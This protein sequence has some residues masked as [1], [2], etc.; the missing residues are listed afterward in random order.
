MSG[1]PA[2]NLHIEAQPGGTV[3]ESVALEKAQ[4]VFYHGWVH[5]EEY[6]GCAKLYVLAQFISLLL[7]VPIV[8]CPEGDERHDANQGGEEEHQGFEEPDRGE[9]GAVREQALDRQ[10]QLL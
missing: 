10:H 3:D 5:Q 6:N 1:A 7:L 8:H 2:L 9:G 4:R